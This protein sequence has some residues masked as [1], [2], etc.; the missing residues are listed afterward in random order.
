MASMFD[1]LDA[2]ASDA[3]GDVFHEEA[4]LRP[5]RSSQYAERAVDPDRGQ[6]LVFGVFSA[7]PADGE[8]KGQAVGAK[9]TGS[10]RISS[11]SA[12]FWI[13]RV[14]V[15]QMV[16][17]PQK[18]DAIILTERP[19]CPTYAISQVEPSDMGDLNLIL[20]RDDP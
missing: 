13:P 14:E 15:E 6:A 9:F 7:G 12:E 11:M 4:V 5:R 19:G 16:H 1:D 2:M 10:T 18:G 20:V 17:R 3:I 8:L